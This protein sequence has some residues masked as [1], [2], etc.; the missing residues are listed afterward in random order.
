MFSILHYEFSKGCHN[1]Y[2][3]YGYHNLY[4]HLQFV[5]IAYKEN[6]LIQPTL[7]VQNNHKEHDQLYKTNIIF[8]VI[9]YNYFWFNYIGLKGILTLKQGQSWWWILTKT[10][11]VGTAVFDFIV[12][13]NC[14][15]WAPNCFVIISTSWAQ[16][17]TSDY[18]NNIMYIN[19]FIISLQKSCILSPIWSPNL[20]KVSTMKAE[21][22]FSLVSSNQEWYWHMDSAPEI[23]VGWVNLLKYKSYNFSQ[24]Y[25]FSQGIDMRYNYISEKWILWHRFV[26]L[27]FSHPQ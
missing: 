22:L 26:Q 21:I 13:F 6:S 25:S 16:V 17:I 8:L 11:D 2:W 27:L 1:L 4:L 10:C 23:F 12:I 5:A 9:K 14:S 7:V 15:S 20:L 24:R 19:I 3:H 18:E